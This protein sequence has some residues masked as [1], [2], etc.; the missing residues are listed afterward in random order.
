MRLNTSQ[1]NNPVTCIT[2][3]ERKVKQSHKHA[4]TNTKCL[5]IHTIRMKCT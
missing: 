1:H 3:A 4:N 5:M 2:E